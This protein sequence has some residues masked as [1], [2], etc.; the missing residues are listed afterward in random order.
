MQILEGI[1]IE[2]AMGTFDKFA[3]FDSSPATPGA[4]GL[5]PCEARALLS[6]HPSQ[7][8]PMTRLIMS[9]GNER[10]KGY[11]QCSIDLY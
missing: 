2:I 11:T 8:S 3:G 1:S 6:A 9:Q 4:S 10:Y 7:P 5:T